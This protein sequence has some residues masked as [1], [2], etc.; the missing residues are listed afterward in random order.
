MTLKNAA[1]GKGESEVDAAR[2]PREL[3][4]YD[5]ASLFE[6]RAYR[7]EKPNYRF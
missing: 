5:V 4:P 3:G 7:L 2:G 1:A 6:A